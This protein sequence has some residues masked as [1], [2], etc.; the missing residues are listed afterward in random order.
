MRAIA[1]VFIYPLVLTW[2]TISCLTG[3]VTSVILRL[4]QFTLGFVPGKMWAPLTMWLLGIKVKVVGLENIDQEQ[5]GIF[6]S[7]HGSYLDIPVSVMSIPLKMNFIAKKELRHVP[8]VGWYISAT[9][10]I[11]VDRKN[12]TLAMKSMQEAARRINAGKNVLSYAEGSRSKDGAI[13]TFRRGAFIIAKEGDV[14]ITPIA[15]QGAYEC[16]PPTSFFTK[17]G[18]ITLVIGEAFRPSDFPE[19]SAEQL[20]EFTRQKVIALQASVR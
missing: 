1:L 11:F 4:P 14:R 2:M 10:Q 8:V 7:N 18:T 3:V 17:R 15:I 9:K 19:K 16:L 20:S 12:R 6:V 13:H 5:H